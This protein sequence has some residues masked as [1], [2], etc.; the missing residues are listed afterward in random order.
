MLLTSRVVRLVCQHASALRVNAASCHSAQ[1][2]AVKSE[3]FPLREKT[4]K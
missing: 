3:R 2:G 1:S 4:A